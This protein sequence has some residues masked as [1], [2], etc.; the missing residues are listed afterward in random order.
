MG[1]PGLCRGVQLGGV[2]D[3]QVAIQTD[4]NQQKDPA[5]EVDL[6]K[7]KGKLKL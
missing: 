7:R 4:A 5:V 3:G 1:K 2:D 6:G